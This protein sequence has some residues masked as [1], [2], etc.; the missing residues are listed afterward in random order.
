MFRGFFVRSVTVADNSFVGVYT[1]IPTQTLT[2]LSSCDPPNVSL[3][4][5]YL[6]APLSLL[7]I[8]RNYSQ[9]S[10]PQY[11]GFE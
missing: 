1:M 3:A 2:R 8:E 11:D 9:Q 7:Y 4:E 5:I 6:C 10:C